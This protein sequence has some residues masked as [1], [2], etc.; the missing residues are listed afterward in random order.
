MAGLDDFVE[1][2]ALHHFLAELFVLVVE[3]VCV[4]VVLDDVDVALVGADEGGVGGAEE[5][6]GGAV[7]ADCHVQG[8]RVVGDNERGACDECHE[9]RDIG[10]AD[11]VDDACV[12]GG[13]QRLALVALAGCA[14]DGDTVEAHREQVGCERGEAVY[15]PALAGPDAGGCDDGVAGVAELGVSV[16][17]LEGGGVGV[18]GHVADGRDAGGFDEGEHTVDAVEGGWDIVFFGESEPAHLACV[19]V[20]DAAWCA[21]RPGE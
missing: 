12:T 18:E 5:G 10:V 9:S 4:G 11:E 2:D 20:A 6:D 13:E 17:T 16:D 8:G 19:C 1:G 14:D 7:E 3:R 21:G 15:G